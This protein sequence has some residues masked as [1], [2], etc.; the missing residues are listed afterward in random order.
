[1][2]NTLQAPKDWLIQVSDLGKTFG[3]T[4][5]LQDVSFRLGQGEIL[6]IIGPSGGGKTTLLRCLD[7]LER[8]DS[9]QIDFGW[10]HNFS[11]TSAGDEEIMATAGKT[12]VAPLEDLVNLLRRDIGF[13]FQG[14]NLWE[15]RTVASNL[16]LAPMVVLR[17]SRYEATSKAEELCGRFG[18]SKRLHSRIWE[19]SG[20]QRQ[21]VA[22]MRALMMGPKVMLLDEIT[23]ALDPVLTVYVMQAIKQLRD[24]GLA[25][26]IVTHHIE[27][28]SSLCDR[29]LFLSDGRLIQL[30]TPDR[31]KQSP[32]NDEVRAFLDVLKLA[33]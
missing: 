2:D 9:G 15:E 31:L 29:L 14:F 17:W 30:D 28:A 23:S 13:V 19:L 10:S 26:I 3:G 32:A 33:R 1:V 5:V 11:V 12:G 27:F 6:G 22:I 24:E 25:M 16:I 21:R 7:L 4:S 8:I 18:L 20:G